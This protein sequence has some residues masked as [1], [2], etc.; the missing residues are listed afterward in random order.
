M[1]SGNLFPLAPLQKGGRYRMRYDWIARLK[2]VEQ[3]VERELDYEIFSIVEIVGIDKFLEIFKVMEKLPYYFSYKKLSP[4]MSFY[5]SQEIG[6]KSIPKIA[7]EMG[8]TVR[9]VQKIVCE[10][11]GKGSSGAR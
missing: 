8:V 9:T 3:V 4:L 1:G 7:R 2:D 10:L 5:V 6:S 11:K